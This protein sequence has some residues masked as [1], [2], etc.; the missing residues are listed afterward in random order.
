MGYMERYEEWLA[1]LPENDPMREELLAIKD[2]D[3]E[4][5][6]RF[7]REIEFGTAGLRGI[8]AAGTNRM[9]TL[10]VG[11]ATQGIANYILASGENPHRGIAI[12][13]DSRYHSKE[14]AE[15]AAEILAGNGIKVYLFP[16]LRPTP[17][18]SFIRSTG[19]TARRSR[20]RSPTECLRRSWRWTFLTI[21]RGYRCRMLLMREK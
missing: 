8:C 1:K 15:L 3:K 13:Y 20:A 11:R 6:E 17:E 14:F 19:W 16:S 12:A 10:T 18:L 5:R 4:I 9:N 2:N 7:Y 21:S